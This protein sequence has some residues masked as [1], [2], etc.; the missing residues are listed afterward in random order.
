[1]L[2]QN[3]PDIRFA[4]D[5]VAEACQLTRAVHAALGGSH[6]E[7][8]DLSP[9]S[10]A[11][12]SVQALAGKRLFEAFP[13]AVLVGEESA[14]ILRGP[15]GEAALAHAVTHTSPFAA[16]ATAANICAW[17]DRGASDSGT[18]FWTLDPVDGT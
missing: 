18:R 1:M 16:D 15:H 3:H 7:K 11:D 8:S 2:D 10:V 12:L 17:I 5:F 4:L 13:D 9:V 14:D 6:L